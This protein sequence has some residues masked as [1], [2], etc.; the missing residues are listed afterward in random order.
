M[1]RARTSV[2]CRGL[3]PAYV[4]PTDP[5][6]RPV[7]FKLIEYLQDGIAPDRDRAKT[8]L[9][10]LRLVMADVH[11]EALKQLIKEAEGD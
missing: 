8:I 5:K 11:P 6:T 1:T 7:H 2:W 3:G 10:E 9:A 4:D